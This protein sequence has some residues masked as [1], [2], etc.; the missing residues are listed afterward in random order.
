MIG[1][2]VAI[3]SD[4]LE[5][6]KNNE[7]D[8]LDI[9]TDEYPTLDI[10]KSWQVIHFLL[11]D[12]IDDGEPPLGNVIPMRD[13]NGLDVEMDYGAFAITPKEALD[14]Y[15]AIKDIGKDE[16]RQK[17]DFESLLKNEIYPVVDDEDA[18]DFFDY[19]YANFKSIQAFYQMASE[20]HYGII[21][22]IM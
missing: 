4:K 20:N 17:Y 13:D 9:D 22:Y 14:A 8:L 10:D 19:M 3:D 5:Q 11:C 21:F 12:E 15:N 18:N 2:Y 16:L 1:N 7:L 6:I